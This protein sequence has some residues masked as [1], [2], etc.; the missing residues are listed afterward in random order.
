[1]KTNDAGR[2]LI[3]RHEGLK[4]EAYTCSAGV[5]T[6]GYGHTRDPFTG[7]LDVKPGQKITKH[8]A[9][10]IFDL[11][12]EKFELAVSRAC[13]GANPNQFA[14]LVSLAFNIGVKQFETSKLVK[15]FN[16]GG[17]LAAA[18]EFAKWKHAGKNADGTPRVDPGLVKRRAA[19]RALFLT[20]PS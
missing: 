13:P 12:L 17:P 3:K 15:R 10:V 1:M 14:A 5:W 7:E 20:M 4:L 6:I 11:D 16:T 19:E 9:E 8:Q 2:D 18:P